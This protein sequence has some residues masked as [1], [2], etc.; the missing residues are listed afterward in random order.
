MG[1]P[2]FHVHFLGATH[3][4]PEPEV[5]PYKLSEYLYSS[6]SSGKKSKIKICHQVHVY[7]SLTGIIVMFVHSIHQFITFFVDFLI[8]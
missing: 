4:Q 1:V 8:I 5:P 2:K 7:D 6:D 3:T